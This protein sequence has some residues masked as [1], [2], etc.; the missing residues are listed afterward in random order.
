M[1]FSA[2]ALLLGL[3]VAA[4]GCAA[5]RQ[6]PK[7][8]ATAAQASPPA[9]NSA[10]LTEA[11]L[12]KLA[13]EPSLA[14]PPGEWRKL[15]DGDDLVGW[16]ATDF[17]G[18]G[19]VECKHGMIVLGMGD[20]FTGVN[21]TNAFPTENYEI[22]LEAARLMG[23]DFFCGLTFPV[24]NDFCSL[25]V[26]GWGGSLVGISS[27]DGMDASE[28]ETTRYHSFDDRRW[29]QIRLRV[30]LGRIEAWI[31]GEKVVNVR[32]E[33]KRVSVRAG[34]IEESEPFGIACWQTSAA[35]RNVAFRA[36]NGPAGPPR[37]G[38]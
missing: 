9:S 29:Y 11:D 6:S 26:G 7:P 21:Y 32:T 24:T 20:P 8:I 4:A 16:R 28:N 38:Y 18:H 35:L 37:K 22:S 25:I 19:D 10:S 15:F 3:A 36:V 2:L 31:D 1:K 13:A 23:S 5:R 27:L 30:S 12:T 17:A 14:L 33:G 34:D